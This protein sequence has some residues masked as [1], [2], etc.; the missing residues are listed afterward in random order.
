MYIGVY[1]GS[2]LTEKREV[3]TNMNH[4]EIKVLILTI[5]MLS[6]LIYCIIMAIYFYKIETKKLSATWIIASVVVAIVVVWNCHLIM[7]AISAI[8][9]GKVISIIS[10][11]PAL[12]LVIAFYLMFYYYEKTSILFISAGV[13]TFIVSLLIF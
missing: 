13:S 2:N 11:I 9:T 4:N 12:F 6:A 1:D 7:D 8:Y 3:S 10:L 5:I